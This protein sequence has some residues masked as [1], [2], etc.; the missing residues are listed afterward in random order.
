MEFSIGDVVLSCAGRDARQYFVII[1]K[2]DKLFVFIADGL[3]HKLAKPKKKKVKHLKAAGYR[4]NDVAAKL[5]C[6]DVISDSE[7]RKALKS[8]D[9]NTIKGEE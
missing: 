6:G 4:L 3:Q 5:T 2:A 1:E 8:L 7:I 9:L